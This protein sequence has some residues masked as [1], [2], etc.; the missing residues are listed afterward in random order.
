MTDTKYQ[1]VH[2]LVDHL[3]SQHPLLGVLVRRRTNGHN[4]TRARDVL[5]VERHEVEALLFQDLE[6]DVCVQLAIDVT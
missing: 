2:R 4:L 3:A 6:R 1:H 5:H